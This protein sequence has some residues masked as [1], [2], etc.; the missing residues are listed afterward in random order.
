[1]A[2]SP[3]LVNRYF[4]NHLLTR[5]RVQG[6][7]CFSRPTDLAEKP[8]SLYGPVPGHHV[9]RTRT[10]HLPAA[11]GEIGLLL[12]HAHIG[13]TV[14]D[15]LQAFPEHLC[16]PGN[17]IAAIRRRAAKSRQKDKPKGYPQANLPANKASSCRTGRIEKPCGKPTIFTSSGAHPSPRHPAPIEKSAHSRPATQPHDYTIPDICFTARWMRQR[18]TQV[19][20]PARES[21]PAAA[22]PHAQNAF[23]APRGRNPTCMRMA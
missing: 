1:M 8:R 17:E 3:G 16:L 23:P 6:P 2:Q 11:P 13:R 18:G 20:T 14:L 4:T 15:R 19:R 5:P 10:M 9:S 12:W 21:R 22:E 7:G